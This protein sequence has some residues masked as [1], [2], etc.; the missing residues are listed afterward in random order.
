MPGKHDSALLS[1]R[2]LL[3][4]R[5]LGLS[6]DS[7]SSY[8]LAHLIPFL[9]R[10]ELLHHVVQGGK[11]HL[12]QFMEVLM[13]PAELEMIMPPYHSLSWTRSPYINF[14]KVDLPAPLGPTKASLVSKS[15]PHQICHPVYRESCSIVPTQECVSEPRKACKAVPS[16]ECHAEPRTVCSSIPRTHCSK[17]PVHECKTVP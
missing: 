14:S 17:S 9:E 16:Q 2:E 12:E 3:Y 5:C 8:Y 13:V 4:R 6:C 7:I 1:I 11:V 15:I 10:G